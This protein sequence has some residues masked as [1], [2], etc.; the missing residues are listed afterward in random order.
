[1]QM[2]LLS[3]YTPEIR[4]EAAKKAPVVNAFDAA[5]EAMDEL[6]MDD[7]KVE[8]LVTRA[9]KLIEQSCSFCARRRAYQERW[10]VLHCQ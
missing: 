4:A 2:P 9:D 10:E 3:M 7:E 5:Y 1:M 6:G 8:R